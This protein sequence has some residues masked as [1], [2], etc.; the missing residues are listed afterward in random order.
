VSKIHLEEL[1]LTVLATSW[2]GATVSAP[3]LSL[4]ALSFYTV[5]IYDRTQCLVSAYDTSYTPYCPNW[6]RGR[7][8]LLLLVLLSIRRRDGVILVLRLGVLGKA[9]QGERWLE[10]GSGY[11]PL[12]RGR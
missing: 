12:P 2:M 5:S 10:G 3:F 1:E 7:P 9:P 4:R 8:F 11:A 6:K